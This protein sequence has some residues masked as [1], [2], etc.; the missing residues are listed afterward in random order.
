MISEEF[1][2]VIL[3]VLKLDDFNIQDETKAN[4]I[5]GWDSLNHI[6]VVLA[7][8]EHFKIRFKGYEVIKCKNVG[9]L[10][11]LVNSKLQK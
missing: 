10:H 4:Q 2:N 7:I 3:K 1:K 11:T 8:E 6:N 5:P 9:Q